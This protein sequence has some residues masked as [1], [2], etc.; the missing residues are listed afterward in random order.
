MLEVDFGIFLCDLIEDFGGGMLSGCLLKVVQVGGFL[1]VYILADDFDFL[2]DY[3]VFVVVGVML[4]YGGIV[5]FDNMV[6]MVKQVEFVMEFC[7]EESCGKCIF[8]CIG[9][10]CGVEIISKICEGENVEVNFELVEELCIVMMD[11]LLCVM[12]GLI[13]MLVMSVLCYFCE[14]FIFLDL[15]FEDMVDQDDG[16]LM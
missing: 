7:V 3:E 16:K 6:D 10:I 11:G 1:G 12:G 9:L 8:C 4:G 2:M 5:V 14:D 13:L 15:K